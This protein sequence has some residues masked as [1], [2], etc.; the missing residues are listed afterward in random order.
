MTIG[1]FDND[2]YINE[3]KQEPFQDEIERDIGPVHPRHN[4]GTSRQNL[5]NA[6]HKLLEEMQ[7]NIKAQQQESE[8]QAA[9]LRED[10]II[11]ER[12]AQKRLD[13]EL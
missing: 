4:P 11:R 9:K 7:Q 5:D 2:E 3:M 6:Q 12:K 13:R 10:N 1:S 8:K